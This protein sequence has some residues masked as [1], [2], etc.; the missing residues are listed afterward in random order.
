MTYIVYITYRIKQVKKGGDMRKVELYQ[1]Q[2]GGLNYITTENFRPVEFGYEPEITENFILLIEEAWMK[3]M[4]DWRNRADTIGNS[5]RDY[6][7]GSQIEITVDLY[8]D[9]ICDKKNNYKIIADY[10]GQI[11]RFFISNFDDKLRTFFFGNHKRLKKTN[12][13][14]LKNM[15]KK[16]K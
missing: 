13:R 3:G 7:P 16:T 15:N 1:D 8:A 10:D 6:Y 14:I 9:T 12:L 5:L 11:M 4:A 2:A